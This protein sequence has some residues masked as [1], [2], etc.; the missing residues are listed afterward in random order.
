MRIALIN[1]GSRPD[2]LQLKISS[3]INPRL[4]PILQQKFKNI[5]YDLPKSFIYDASSKEIKAIEDKYVQNHGNLTLRIKKQ[6]IRINHYIPTL[7]VY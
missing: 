4:K 3:H 7:R 2:N 5:T 6:Q 1:L